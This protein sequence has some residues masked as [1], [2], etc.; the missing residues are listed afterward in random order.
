MERLVLLRPNNYNGIALCQ[1]SLDGDTIQLQNGK[2]IKVYYIM[3]AL[4]TL[5]CY[6]HRRS[7]LWEII[8]FHHALKSIQSQVVTHMCNRLAEVCGAKQSIMCIYNAAL[9]AW[10]QSGGRIHVDDYGKRMSTLLT[11]ECENEYETT[12]MCFTNTTKHNITLS[13]ERKYF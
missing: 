3:L 4:F 7:I 8:A 13:G 1:H 2:R 12:S 11:A 5:R 10:I 9:V 6:V